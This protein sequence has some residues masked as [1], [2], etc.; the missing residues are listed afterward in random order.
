MLTVHG[1]SKSYLTLAGAIVTAVRDINFVL[2]ELEFLAIVGPSGC[3]KSTLL[4]LLAGIEAPSTGSIRFSN[5]DAPPRIGFVFQAE[6]IFPWRTVERNL[7]YPLEL[8]GYSRSERKRL[9]QSL[10]RLVGLSPEIFLS[11]YPIELSGGEVRRVSIGMAL[12]R[13]ANLLLLD[14]P[15]SQLDSFMKLR[16]QGVLQDIWVER[17][18]TVV[19]VTHDLEEAFLLADRILIM[20]AGRVVGEVR[21]DTPRPRRLDNLDARSFADCRREILRH[22]DLAT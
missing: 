21:V 5:A 8:S 19:C 1:V 20:K 14:E 11:K 12:A 7:S 18:L 2:P 16:I 3:G 10:C 17:P 4:R 9:A 15:T 13:E 22:Y 6:A